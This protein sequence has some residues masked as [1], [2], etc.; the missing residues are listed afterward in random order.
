MS[1]LFTTK[2][3]SNVLRLCLLT[4]CSPAFGFEPVA[5]HGW[6]YAYFAFAATSISFFSIAML[7]LRAYLWLSYSVIAALLIILMAS[8]D[9]TLAFM[10]SKGSRFVKEAPLFIGA[11]T[12]AAGFVQSAY[13][14][15]PQSKLKRFAPALYALAASSLTLIPGY[16]FV[17]ILP[18]LYAALNVLLLLMLASTLLPPLSWPAVAPTHRRLAVWAP[19]LFLALILGLYLVDFLGADFVMQFR[20]KVNRL[21]VLAY[22]FYGM[23]F[24]LVYLYLQSKATL[25]AERDVEVAARKAA[26]DELKLKS[27]QHDFE[28]AARIAENRYTQLR[29]ASHDIR[30]PIA[31]LR[32]AV[33]DLKKS[34]SDENSDQLVQIIDYLDQ[35]ASSYLRKNGADELPDSDEVA[36]DESGNEAVSTELLLN[37]AMK[38][39]QQEA[40]ARGVKLSADDGGHQVRVQ[41][42]IVVRLLS[43]LI[44][45][46]LNHAHASNIM[47]STALQGDLVALDVRDDGLGIPAE[48]LDSVQQPGLRGEQSEGSGLGLSI[49]ASHAQQQGWPFELFSESGNGTCARL[50]LPLKV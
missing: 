50:L 4:T 6:D 38:L 7:M 13:L 41:P 28:R 2:N 19:A 3:A 33:T 5:P 48:L 21:A 39:H 49:V 22:L 47:L 25:K 40:N 44:A 16:W 26:E 34:V 14:T 31:A 30:Q 24:G 18:L 43:N 11:V 1:E 42:L 23:G 10:L 8:V 20:D 9:G 17:A 45:N 29:E 27:A 35:L 15:D 32:N 36:H 12:A 46:A 37:T